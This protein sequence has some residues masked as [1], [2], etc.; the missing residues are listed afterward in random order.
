MSS[1]TFKSRLVL[2]LFNMRLH[3]IVV[4]NPL[5]SRPQPVAY[6]SHI[7]E[8]RRIVTRIQSRSRNENSS[9]ESATRQWQVKS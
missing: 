4:C 7:S 6:T 1:K 5:G 8:Q 9:G 2:I 3:F